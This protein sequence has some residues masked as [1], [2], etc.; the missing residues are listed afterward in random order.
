MKEGCN[1]L[2]KSIGVLDTTLRDGA[3]S[4][5]VSYTVKDKLK[6]LDILDALG[7]GFAEAGAPAAVAKDEELFLHLKRERV[8]FRTLKP[9]AFHSTCREGVA[10]CEDELLKKTVALADEYVS[11]YGKSSLAQVVSVIRTSGDENLRMIADSV[12]YCRENGKRVIFEGEHFFDGFRADPD[13][14]LQ[15]LVAAVN[16][17]AERVVLCDTNGGSMPGEVKRVVREV[18]KALS[19]PVGIHC[20]NDCGLAVANTLFAVEGGASD[21]H[22]TFCGIGERCGNTDLCTVIPDLQLKMGLSVLPPDRLRLLTGSARRIADIT[23]I[24]FDERAPYVGGYA[25]R[26]KAGAHIDGEEKWSSAFQHTDPAQVGNSSGI[27][28]SDQS[29][30]AAVAKRLRELAPD[31]AKNDPCVTELLARIKNEERLGYQYEN[32]DG[33]LALMMLDALGRRKRYFELLDFKIVLSDPTKPDVLTGCLLKIAVGGSEALVASE[34]KGPVNAIDI[35]LRKALCGFY[36]VLGE[37]RLTDY[38]VRVIDSD[39][40]TAAKVRV[41]V[42]SSDSRSVWRTVG[43]STDIIEA[44]WIAL[45]DSIDYMLADADGLV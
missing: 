11:L 29:G 37:M 34:G 26:H 4:A 5:S 27:L 17:G 43:V 40:A 19:V 6:I 22:G 20:H 33:S 1:A 15:T 23:N 12:A 31:T 39:A 2:K 45:C 41:S 21:V 24:A 13:Y 30:R 16:A 9:V 36:P 8:R 25:F 10:A 32:A 44:S 18:C 3:Q 35:A 28:I 14:A 38:T 42:E 7:I